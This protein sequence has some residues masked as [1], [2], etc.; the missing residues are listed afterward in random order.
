MKTPSIAYLTGITGTVAPVLAQTLQH[1]GLRIEGRHVRVNRDE[2]IQSSLEDVAS[3][4]AQI[5]IHLA[6]GPIAWAKAL[7]SYAYNHHLTF[8]YVSTASVY[9]DQGSGPYTVDSPVHAKQGYGLYKYQCEEAVK[10][11]NPLA[12]I[13]RIGWQIDPQQSPVTN[14]MFRFFADQIKQQGNI[15]VSSKFYPSCSFL[16]DTTEAM[17]QM[18]QRHP[19]GLYFINGNHRL[20]L[21]D[22][23]IKLNHQF[24][25]SW[26]IEATEDFK[27]NDV[28]IDP[29]LPIPF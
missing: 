26:T 25:L 17:Y 19:P 22:I 4:Q 23:A 27:R 7:A 9:D 20:S 13:V 14:N 1:H 8:V 11:V 15:R 21:Y 10:E 29:R 24:R 3:T 2:D 5:I 18:I 12:Y 16:T 28:L 6:L